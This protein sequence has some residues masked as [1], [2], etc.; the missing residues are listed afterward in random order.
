MITL[1]EA[2]GYRCLRHIHQPLGPFH[3]LVGPNASG[4]TTFLDVI[5]FLGSLVSD[6]IEAAVAERTQSFYDLLWKRAGQRFELALEARIPEELRGSLARPDFDTVRYEI[7][8]GIDPESLELGL[9]AEKVLLKTGGSVGLQQALK[10]FF[11]EDPEAPSSLLFAKMSSREAQTVINKVP[12]GNDN[13]YSETGKGWVPAF[14]LG[15][16]RSALSNLPA[17]ESKFPVSTWLRDLLRVGVQQLVLNSLLLRK[18]S[19]PGQARGFK[20]DGSNLPWVI[21]DLE[22]RAPDRLRQWVAHLQTAFPDIEGIQTI[23]RPEDKHRYLLVKYRGGVEIPSWMV[24]DGTLRMLALTLPAYL[25]GLKGIYL[26]EEPEN[27]IHPRAI[28]TMFQSLSS[29]YDAQ[30]LLA[31]HSPVILNI[32][33]ASQVLCFAKTPEGATDIVK[34]S[35]HPALAAWRQET[36]LGLLFAAGVLG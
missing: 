15:P 33:D 31:T 7:A 36:N 21:A 11:P 34:G 28:E 35:E 3:V 16:R 23:E 22:R 20:P 9:Q 29:V 5:A 8:L 19:P 18:A 6:G 10:W 27:G 25:P 13:F 24:S 4:K 17:D 26:I 12:G 30:V 2:L 14:K 1:V 32:V